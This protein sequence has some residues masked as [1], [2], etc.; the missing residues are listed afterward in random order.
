MPT[1]RSKVTSKVT[2]MVQY[3]HNIRQITD[4]TCVDIYIYLTNNIV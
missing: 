4:D 3:I 1:Y 2:G